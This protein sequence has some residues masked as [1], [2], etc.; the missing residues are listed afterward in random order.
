MALTTAQKEFANVLAK[1]FIEI[2][3]PPAKEGLTPQQ[4]KDIEIVKAARGIGGCATDNLIQLLELV[5]E[6]PLPRDVDKTGNK[7]K[8]FPA[9][10]VLHLTAVT[11]S[12]DYKLGSECV[13][14]RSDYDYGIK[15]T[16][17]VG[18]HLP[19]ESKDQWEAN[20]RLA[21]K[22]EIQL[23]TERLVGNITK[24]MGT[25]V[26]IDAS[27]SAEAKAFLASIEAFGKDTETEEE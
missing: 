6:R 17:R 14:Y 10:T 12:H 11:N 18:N 16:G 1:K 25:L 13:V 20:G 8:L 24:S 21:T 23:F 15:D 22:D 27:I 2:T 19:F 9:G 26:M 3:Y 7:V 4:L 5:L